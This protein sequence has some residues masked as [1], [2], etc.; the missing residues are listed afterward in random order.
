MMAP[1]WF[2]GTCALIC[3]YILSGSVT[4]AAATAAAAQQQRNISVIVLLPFDNSYLFSMARVRPALEFAIEATER[5]GARS[6]LRPGGRRFSLRFADSTCGNQAL[7]AAVDLHGERA[8]DL[9]V[10][11][12]CV[13][14]AAPVVRLAS[15]W[16]VPVVTAGALAAGFGA[17]QGEYAMLTRVAPSYQKLGVF[18]LD[19]LRS[20]QWSRVSLVYHD[21]HEERSCYFA[22]EG[23]HLALSESENFSVKIDGFNEVKKESYEAMVEEIR[24]TGRVA[25]I[26]A[27]ADTVRNIMLEAQR[28][29]MTNGD[30]VFFNIELFNSTIYGNGNWLRDDGR[31][32]EARRAFRALKTVTLLRSVRPE[33]E[34]F[35]VAMRQRSLVQHG[36]D[37]GNDQVNMFVEG[38]HDAMVL[39]SLALHDALSGAGNQQAEPPSGLE[40]TRLMWN[41]TFQGI[42]GPVSI[43]DNGDREGDFSVLGMTDGDT[44]KQEVITNY[45]GARRAFENTAAMELS[46]PGGSPPPNTPLYVV[47]SSAVSGVVIGGFV[48]C[49]AVLIAAYVVRRRYTVVVMR[50]SRLHGEDLEKH[51]RLREDS[52]RSHFSEA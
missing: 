1:H 24:S 46:W 29:G 44:G 19:L 21:D 28:K 42:A 6:A 5:D 40:V 35:T 45:Y 36:F 8:P 26:C 13:Y 30:F 23:V 9:I 16:N 32:D 52:V 31:N 33:F 3:C 49:A 50:R 41:R 47:R 48:L 34:E 12:A 43:D 7:F 4:T 10:G 14:A 25:V 38:F 2:P 27:S 51:S 17:K 15:H 22:A 11:P 37:Y 20:F 18:F 39:Y